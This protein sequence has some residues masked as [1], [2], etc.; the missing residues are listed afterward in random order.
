MTLRLLITE[1]AHNDIQRNALWW[2]ANHSV[3]E[4]F[5]WQNAVYDQLAPILALPDS[6]SLC[7]EN[8]HFPYEIREKYVGLGYG[9]YRA[10]FT[11]RDDRL[12]IL[13]VRSVSERPL[14]PS[15]L[16]D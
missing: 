2:A 9:G 1:R 6:H 11:V 7:P 5:T 15:D 8:P 12:Q 14:R 3:D 16:V 10:I 4:A 13:T